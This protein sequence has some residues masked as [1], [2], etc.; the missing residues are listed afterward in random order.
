MLNITPFRLFRAM[1][2]G[3]FLAIFIQ[4]FLISLAYISGT[5][6]V[7]TLADGEVVLLSKIHHTFDIL[8]TYGD[9][10]AIDSRIDKKR[11]LLD[12]IDEPLK[13]GYARFSH[14]ANS[15]DIW[16]KRVIGLPGDTIEITDGVLYRNGEKI[17]ETYILEPM[18]KEIP[19]HYIVPGGTVFV[20]GDNRN[21]S[22]D[23]REIGAV[24][25]DHILGKAIF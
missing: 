15:R 16:I 12:D 25:I 10:V 5:S 6:M 11:T 3:V 20:M 18:R 4:V 9:V 7:P 24:P 17:E 13:N 23:S 21:H 8:P 22:V 2:L 1:I 14:S 19:Q